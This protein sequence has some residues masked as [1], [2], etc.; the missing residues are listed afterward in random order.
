MTAD[1]AAGGDDMTG[2]GT[3]GTAADDASMNA[4]V[5]PNTGLTAMQGADDAGAHEAGFGQQRDPGA[6]KEEGGNEQAR[7]VKG[8]DTSDI[9]ADLSSG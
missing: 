5:N 2:G 3:A 1:F 6:A 4:S 9:P 7:L 8:S